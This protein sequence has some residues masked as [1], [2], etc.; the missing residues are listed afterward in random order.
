MTPAQVVLRWHLE[1]GIVMIP[2]SSH[3]ARI[4]ENFD[5]FGFSLDKDDI[6]AIDALSS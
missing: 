5:L 6:S 3:R 1:H 4:E 2:K